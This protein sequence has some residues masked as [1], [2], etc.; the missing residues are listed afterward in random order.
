MKNLFFI[1]S[2]IVLGLFFTGC[3]GIKYLTIE[4]LEPA[5]VTLPGNVRTI[6]VANNVVQQPNDIGH[7]NQLLGRSG[8]QR[9]NVSS[10]SISVFYT[11]A[12]SQF[13]N[14]EAFFDAVL[15][16]QEPLRSDHDFFTEQPIS[17]DKMNELR[18]EHHVDAI[19]SLDKLLIET[20]KD[21]HF[22]QQGYSWAAMKA[23]IQSI[24]RVYLPSMTGQIPAVH[25]TDSLNWQGF[26]RQNGYLYAEEILPSHEEAMKEAAVYAAEKMT[27]VFSP[28]WVMQD[29]WFYTLP[30]ALMREG[31]T[32]AQNKDWVNA[33]SKW[34]AF[35][36]KETNELKKA[37][38]ASN[39]A[40]AYEML[41]DMQ[42]ASEWI[43]K[44]EQLFLKATRPD[45]LDR[46]RVQIYKREIDRRRDNSNQLNMQVN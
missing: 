23:N 1:L 35:Y 7:T 9:I 2:S 14:E 45:S 16:R 19:I 31:E 10:D 32:F 21:E 13:L 18:T 41:D 4:T 30:N 40:L 24:V 27:S 6:L 33:V 39:I 43:G 25:F 42:L 26:E 20:H 28:H 3:S 12:L 29:R 22:R 37:K 5:Q 11:E 34:E 8:A 44:S 36:E 38:A 15:Y 46:K 17:P